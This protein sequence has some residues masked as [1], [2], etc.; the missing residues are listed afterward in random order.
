MPWEKYRTWEPSPSSAFNTHSWMTERVWRRYRIGYSVV[1]AFVIGVMPAY[2]HEALISELTVL[3][4]ILNSSFSESKLPF[5][6]KPYLRLPWS[7]LARQFSFP[8]RSWLLLSL[9][10]H[11][12]VSL[13]LLFYRILEERRSQVVDVAGSECPVSDAHYDSNTHISKLE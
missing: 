13:L 3:N 9:S 7:P 2:A 6:L 5:R 1:S 12:L 8:W 10:H 4:L 11:L